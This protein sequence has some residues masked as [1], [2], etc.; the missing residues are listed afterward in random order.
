MPIKTDF[1]NLDYDLEE[2]TN[3]MQSTKV[4]AQDDGPTM[5]LTNDTMEAV[6]ER[7]DPDDPECERF[8]VVTCKADDQTNINLFVQALAE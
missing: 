1:V 6:A 3:A 8:T 5:T 4:N 2:I 7:I